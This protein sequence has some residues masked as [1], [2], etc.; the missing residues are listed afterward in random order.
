MEDNKIFVFLSHSHRD[1]EK[2]REVRDLLEIEGFR[3]LMFFLKCLEK[4]GY[5][6]LT[7]SLIKEEIDS[8]QRFVLCNSKNAAESDWVKFEVEHIKEINRPYEVVDL[9][10][11]HEKLKE[12]IRRF[13]VRSTVFLSYRRSQSMLVNAVCK[14]LEIH[15]FK[16]LYDRNNLMPGDIYT[17]RIEENIITAAEKGYV[18]AFLDH[19]Y[20]MESWLSKELQIAQ[21]YHGRILLVVIESLPPEAEFLYGNLNWIDVKGMSIPEAAKHIVDC[22]LRLD[23]YNNQ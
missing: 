2:V 4:D 14:E 11:S 7:R 22:L 10:W 6:D 21:Q 16:V 13:K 5:E 23:I 20:N 1:Y 19:T 12:A 8:R 3:P 15:D 17:K 9:E 18:L